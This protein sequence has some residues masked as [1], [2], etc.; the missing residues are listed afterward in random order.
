MHVRPRVRSV[1]VSVLDQ[2]REA[3]Q[4]VAR[5]L[6]EL[7]P[8][9]AEYRELEEVAKRLGIDAAA[10]PAPSGTG[11]SRRRRAA[12]ASTTS[13]RTS[14]A[15][16]KSARRRSSRGAASGQRQQQLLELVRQQPGI[17]VRDAAANLGV[18][19]TG[20]YRVVRR[21]EESGDVRKNGRQL[22]PAATAT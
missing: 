15:A 20:L 13:A 17:T 14:S 22:E 10:A 21:L 1:I 16:P 7:E 2:F 5:R 18:D 12:R 11:G 3:E 6:K 19:P 9:V 8:A 4:R